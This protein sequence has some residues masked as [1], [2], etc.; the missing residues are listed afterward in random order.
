MEKTIAQGAEALLIHK[1]NLVIKNRISKGYR[2]PLLD[3]QLRA[4]R[5]RSE[6]KILIKA[7]QLINVPKIIKVDEKNKQITMDFIDGKILSDSLDDF[8][9]SDALRICRIMGENIAVMHKSG[10]I[11]GDLTTS[12]MILSNNEICFIDFGL[13]FHSSR[14]EDKAVDLHLLRQALE[15]KHFHRWE[16]YFGAVS[17]G[18]KKK[19]DKAKETLK[20][21]EKVEAR[22]RYKGKHQTK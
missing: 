20:Q 1:G 19:S 8:K 6:A 16:E 17:Q 7:S 14:I 15:S 3:K 4:R 11:H 12:N 2:H 18:Y 10:I 9:I 13:A 5:T 21:L 22:G